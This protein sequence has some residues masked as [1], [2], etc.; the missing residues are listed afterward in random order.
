MTKKIKFGYPLDLLIDRSTKFKK[1]EKCIG[2]IDSF[3]RLSLEANKSEQGCGAITLPELDSHVKTKAKKDDSGNTGI[4]YTGSGNII[5]RGKPGTAKST[6]ALQMTVVASMPPNN[7]FSFYITLE[8]SPKNIVSKANDFRWDKSCITYNELNINHI[9]NKDESQ[10]NYRS[11]SLLHRQ[12]EEMIALQKKPKVIISTLSP[13]NVF[14]YGNKNDT[15]YHYRYH[16]LEKIL[17]E[18]DIYNRNNREHKIGFVCVD[19]LNVFGDTLLTRTELF[20]LFEL[21]KKY[22][23][24]GIFIV[25]EDEKYLFA[26]EDKLHGATIEYLSD[27]AISL[28]TGEDDGYFLRYF[29]ITK[30]RYQHQ[31]YGKHPFRISQ[32]D[33]KKK[34]P[35]EAIKVL[36]SLHYLVSA[37][38]K[39]DNE[40]YN[41]Q[42]YTWEN[43]GVFCDSD[44]EIYLPLDFKLPKVILIKGPGASFKTTLARD[45]LMNGLLKKS[46]G[47]KELNT[48]VLLIR[49]QDKEYQIPPENLS[50]FRLSETCYDKLINI[51]FSADLLGKYFM[52]EQEIPEEYDPEYKGLIKKVFKEL[53][54]K[55]YSSWKDVITDEND[56]QI[57]SDV[58]N[59]NVYNDFYKIVW[60]QIDYDRLGEIEN[61]KR[62]LFSYKFN[63]GGIERRYTELFIKSGYLLPEEFIQLILELININEYGYVKPTHVVLD[64]VG[65]IGASYPLLYKSKTAGDIFLTALVHIIRNYKMS[66]IITGSTGEYAKADTMINIASILAD[67]VLVTKKINVFG[68]SYVSISGEGL[69]SSEPLSEQAKENVPGIISPVKN[70]L[71]SIE[72]D[73]FSGLVGFNT[74]VIDRPGIDL[75]IYQENEIQE[76]YANEISSLLNFAFATSIDKTGLTSHN[77]I[78]VNSFSR[79]DTTAFHDSLGF[80][81]GSP[82]RKTVVCSIDEFLPIDEQRINKSLT[83]IHQSTYTDL[84]FNDNDANKYTLPFYDNVLLLLINTDIV[85]LDNNIKS[86]LAENSTKKLTWIELEE[87]VN[88]YYKKSP[89]GLVPFD[90]ITES[91]ETK[92]C[93]LLDAIR[94]A[95]DNIPINE[96]INKIVSK[97]ID[98]AK[99]VRNLQAIRTIV[100]KSPKF[101]D[102][103]ILDEDLK[104]VHKIKDSSKKGILNRLFDDDAIVN[105][106]CKAE[107][108]SKHK[109][110]NKKIKTN[111]LYPHALVYVAWYSEIRNLIKSYP[112]LSEKL[113]VYALP[114]GGFKG[115]WRLGILKGSVSPSLGHEVLKLL[116]KEKED[117]KRFVRGVGLPTYERFKSDKEFLAWPGAKYHN[118]EFGDNS[119]L[120]VFDI[121]SKA[122]KRSDIP[123][124]SEF[125]IVFSTIFNELVNL[126]SNSLVEEFIVNR[127]PE[128]LGR[129]RK[130]GH[131]E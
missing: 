82:I 123:N 40:Q 124:Y 85:N 44:T 86:K 103:L 63:D 83:P 34:G 81:E 128:I 6:L 35:I 9:N 29:E 90:F 26:T 105:E 48:H 51:F 101:I 59:D 1:Y 104:K 15:L 53:I 116:C 64:E 32:R 56:R 45:F 130:F 69:T 120:K 12:F 71:F 117:F 14:N 66:L 72:K 2:N 68:D 30:S 4:N 89:N 93:I 111:L 62:Y 131:N 17:N 107:K 57:L 46:D 96:I 65:R 98:T 113:V 67:T 19:S 80:L 79:I 112:E 55:K 47:T 126:K 73:K 129:V 118:N 102:S 38:D 127:L 41:S 121:H 22:K 110:F 25:E 43:T 61:T 21:F 49:F 84:G 122:Q 88:D 50:P 39:P 108:I 109:L 97:K 28:T 60:K 106:L 70:N 18:A 16:Q 115:D 24:I 78:D 99:T 13:R 91:D 23:I 10:S 5:I 54:K 20:R 31:V 77:N 119:L 95:N 33:D 42:F 100:N 114:G 94:S 125:R 7:V 87:I 37:T 3:P 36:P 58:I 8:E 74:N 27:I 92:S 11:K 52:N 75:Y 76:A